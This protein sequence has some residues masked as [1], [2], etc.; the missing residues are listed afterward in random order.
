MINLLLMA[1]VGNLHANFGVGLKILSQWHMQVIQIQIYG[2]ISNY[3]GRS[4]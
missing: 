1:D 4:G 3:N 2:V